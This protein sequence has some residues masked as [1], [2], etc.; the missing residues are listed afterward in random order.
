METYYITLSVEDHPDIYN[1]YILGNKKN[2]NVLQGIRHLDHQ[3]ETEVL[4]TVEDADGVIQKTVRIMNKGSEAA[5]HIGIELE[6][7]CLLYTSRC[8]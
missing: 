7:D 8:V 3:V 6:R 1:V 4:E 2:A 5:I